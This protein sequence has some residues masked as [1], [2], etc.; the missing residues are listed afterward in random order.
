MFEEKC[1]HLK[2][3]KLLKEED[4]VW[5]KKIKIIED[6]KKHGFDKAK[7]IKKYEISQ[8]RVINVLIN[9]FETLKAVYSGI[10][11]DK[12]KS[13]K[14][15][16]LAELEPQLYEWLCKTTRR[17]AVISGLLLKSKDFGS[18]WYPICIF[19]YFLFSDTPRFSDSFLTDQMCH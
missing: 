11:N 7:I 9:Q 19:M 1:H 5:K 16:P 12:I 17:G 18:F 15:S 8:H 4:W 3:P 10:I 2:P 14:K 13:L 6:S